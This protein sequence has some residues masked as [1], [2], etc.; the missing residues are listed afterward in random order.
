MYVARSGF[1]NNKWQCTQN[2]FRF[3]F[4]A[5]DAMLIAVKGKMEVAK[6]NAQLEKFKR[7]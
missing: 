5:V 3:N 7:K 2:D 4:A 6:Q 1:A